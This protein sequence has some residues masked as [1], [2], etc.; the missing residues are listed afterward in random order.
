MP[1]QT[2]YS[3]RGTRLPLA[4][5]GSVTATAPALAKLFQNN[6]AGPGGFY[7]VGVSQT[8]HNGIHLTAEPG[9]PVHCLASGTIVAAR[10]VPSYDETQYPHGS[11]SFVLV[12]HQLAVLKDPEK[13]TDIT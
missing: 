8:W 6:E 5:D 13:D 11:P 3:F 12:K 7:P 2:A 9:K 1:A 10:R 4:V